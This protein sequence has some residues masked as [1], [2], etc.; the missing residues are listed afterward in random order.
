MQNNVQNH[1][2]EEEDEQQQARPPWLMEEL[3]WLSPMDF[4]IIPEGTNNMTWA[5]SEVWD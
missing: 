3:T 4:V 5:N 2:T 1:E